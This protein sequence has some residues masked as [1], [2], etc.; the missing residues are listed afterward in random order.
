MSTG[1][2]IAVAVVILSAAALFYAF[3][4]APPSET[5]TFTTAKKQVEKRKEKADVKIAEI[6]KH[7]K[8]SAK[9]I[10]DVTLIATET[11]AAYAEIKDT[12]A[13]VEDKLAAADAALTACDTRADALVDHVDYLN[14]EISA[15]EEKETALGDEV[16]LFSARIDALEADNATMRRQLFW[17]RVG[18]V[19]LIAA[20][21]GLWVLV[22]L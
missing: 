18:V 2:K 6:K 8:K 9:K 7:V 21:L 11:E 15:H 22:V 16:E 4:P 13:G 17:A 19:G 14:A 1:F 3:R 20:G 5:Q 12:P 10:E